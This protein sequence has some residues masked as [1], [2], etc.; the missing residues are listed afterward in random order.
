VTNAEY[1]AFLDDLVIAGREDE[2]VAA[3]PRAQLGTVA[4]PFF[5]RDANGRFIAGDDE[6]GRPVLLEA[7]VVLVPWHGAVAYARW[8]AARTGLS[9]RLPDE[10]EREK[11]ARGADGRRCPWGDHLDATFACV[12]ES[13]TGE[14]ARASVHAHPLD[15]SPYGVRGLAGNTRDWCGNVWTESGPPVDGG[16]LRV[17]EAAWDNPEHR[18][19]RGG[20]WASTLGYSRAAAR[21]GNRPPMVR[22]VLGFRLARSWPREAGERAGATT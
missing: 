14:P 21:F 9:W 8:L 1:L 10:L 20:A 7:P 11:A 12:A 15:E 3:C 18:A 13:F 22:A 2:A 4:R 17:V 6:V 16:R 5:G 19:L